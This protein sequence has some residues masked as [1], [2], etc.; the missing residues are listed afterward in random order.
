MT[1]VHPR[2]KASILKTVF[3]ISLPICLIDTCIKDWLSGFPFYEQRMS[4][5]YWS[6]IWNAEDCLAQMM[7]IRF[8]KETIISSIFNNHVHILY[9]IQYNFTIVIN[10]YIMLS[11][12]RQYKMLIFYLLKFFVCLIR[13]KR[14]ALWQSIINISAI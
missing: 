8:I 4:F 1:N 6:K 5:A 13:H 11:I 3:H 10:N 2:E 12:N 7:Y 14:I 9:F